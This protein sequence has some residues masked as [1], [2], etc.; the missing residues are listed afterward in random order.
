MITQLMYA[1][2]KQDRM[3][4]FMMWYLN[5]FVVERQILYVYLIDSY[6]ILEIRCIKIFDIE[7][8][9]N[10]CII[11]LLAHLGKKI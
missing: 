10:M 7:I 3:R 4:E 9:I 11:S 6:N 8:I 2:L 1:N 5:K